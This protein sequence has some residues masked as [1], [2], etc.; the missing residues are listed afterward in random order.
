MKRKRP[1]QKRPMTPRRAQARA[2]AKF[3]RKEG[4]EVLSTRDWNIAADLEIDLATASATDAVVD[5]L[6]KRRKG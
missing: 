5:W 2:E 1:T 3:L 6:A 4:S